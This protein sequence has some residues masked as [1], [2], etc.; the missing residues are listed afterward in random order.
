MWPTAYAST[1]VNPTA[2]K[3]FLKRASVNFN[4]VFS[5]VK[6]QW[7]LV[8]FILSVMR[9]CRQSKSFNIVFTMRAAV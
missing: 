7:V 8:H 5:E 3:V 4:V 1:A 2:T 6:G 9:P